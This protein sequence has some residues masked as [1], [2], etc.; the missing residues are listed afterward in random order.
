ME[1]PS[2]LFRTD[3]FGKTY[4]LIIDHG[5][6]KAILPRNRIELVECHTRLGQPLIHRPLDLDEQA[7][8]RLLALS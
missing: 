7:R 8:E 6:H 4:L 5:P 3:E 1:N 2:D